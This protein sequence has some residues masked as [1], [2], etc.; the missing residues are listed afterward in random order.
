[1]NPQITDVRIRDTVVPVKLNA[2]F[3]RKAK[4]K[5]EDAP[6]IHGAEFLRALVQYHR[7][8]L[9]ATNEELRQPLPTELPLLL[10][11][12]EWQHPDISDEELP[13][14]SPS[15][16]MIAEVLYSADKSKYDPSFVHPNTHWTNW[17]R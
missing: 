1:M 5:L 10:Q 2:A 7:L 8:Q 3:F 15:F 9:L 4:V 16:Q 17:V 11:L 14:Q 6:R 13:S 12:D